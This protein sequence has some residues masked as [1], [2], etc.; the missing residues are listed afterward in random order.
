MMQLPDRVFLG[1][2]PCHVTSDR[3]HF[4]GKERRRR[5]QGSLGRW[6]RTRVGRAERAEDEA[7]VD[8]GSQA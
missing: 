3:E 8:T 1:T 6:Q 2:Y 7:G 4:P 5:A